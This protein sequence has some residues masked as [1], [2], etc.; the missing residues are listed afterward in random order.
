MVPRQNDDVNESWISDK[1]RYAY[2]GLK[3]QRLTTPLVKQADGKY[4]QASWEEA[5][6]VVAEQFN[7]VTSGA[8]R[9]Y[10]Y[11]KM[12]FPEIQT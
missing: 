12:W 4:A 10:S 11:T 2:D 6:Q 5:L 8:F 9:T 7:K 1:A 3:R